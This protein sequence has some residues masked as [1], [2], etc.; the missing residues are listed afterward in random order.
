MYQ[1]SL[2]RAQLYAI[3]TTCFGPFC[4]LFMYSFVQLQSSRTK[5]KKLA[6]ISHLCSLWVAWWVWGS[7]SAADYRGR[8]IYLLNDFYIRFVWSELDRQVIIRS[9]LDFTV[10][11]RKPGPYPASLI[12]I[13]KTIFSVTWERWGWYIGKKNSLSDKNYFHWSGW[14]NHS[15]LSCT[16]LYCA[17]ISVLYRG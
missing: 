17:L 13:A 16:F 12:R 2:L 7:H 9:S 4:H 15:L 14:N 5:G 8:E 1:I 6:R 3:D 11:L 10:W